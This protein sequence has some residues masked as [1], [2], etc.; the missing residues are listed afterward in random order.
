MK[1]V[2]QYLRE[3]LLENCGINDLTYETLTKTE[4]SIKFEQLMRNRLILG[5]LRY[6]KLRAIGKKN[7]NRINY[8]ERKIANYKKTKNKECLV[9]IAN[10]CLCEF[11]EGDSKVF[12]P[13]DNK[14]Q[15]KEKENV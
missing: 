5:A 8:I 7:W 2:N 12:M 14:T 4:W 15:C 10:L 13:E 3:H 11:I 6:G 1:T 9:D